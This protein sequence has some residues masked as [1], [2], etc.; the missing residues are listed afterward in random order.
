MLLVTLG[1]ATPVRR[2]GPYVLSL[3]IQPCNT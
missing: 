3:W 2:K 1:R